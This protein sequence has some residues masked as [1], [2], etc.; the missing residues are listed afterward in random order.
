[1][2]SFSDMEGAQDFVDDHCTRDEQLATV[3]YVLLN[4][5]KLFAAYV[6]FFPAML[7]ALFFAWYAKAMLNEF[8]YISGKSIIARKVS[9]VNKRKA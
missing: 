7:G 4:P 2:K 3:S 8:E 1:M 6:L 5:F 9:D